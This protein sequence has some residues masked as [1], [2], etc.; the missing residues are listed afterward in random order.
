MAKVESLAKL[1]TKKANAAKRRG[2][3]RMMIPANVVINFLEDLIESNEKL[4]RLHER[5]G[6]TNFSNLLK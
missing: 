6:E 2:S 1:W 4:K 5:L 3:W